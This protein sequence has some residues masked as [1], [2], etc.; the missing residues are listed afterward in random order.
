MGIGRIVAA[1]LNIRIDM[2]ISPTR[3]GCAS[4]GTILMFGLGRIAGRP[5][6]HIVFLIGPIDADM[7][8]TLSGCSETDSFIFGGG[9]MV[10]RAA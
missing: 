10:V 6:D 7:G 2:E 1:V 9:L 4:S 3:T 8:A 5:Q